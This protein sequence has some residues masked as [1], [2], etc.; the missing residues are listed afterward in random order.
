MDPF[1]IAAGISAL[2]GIFKGIT[3]LFRRQRRGP[4]RQEQ[5]PAGRERGRG[6]R[7]RNSCRP[8]TRS[9]PRGRRRRRQQRRRRLRRLQPRRDQP[10]LS[11]AM[12]NARSRRLPRPH[13]GAGRPIPGPGRQDP[14]PRPAGR[15]R[16]QAPFPRSSAALLR[17]PSSSGSRC[18]LSTLRGTG[19]RQPLR[20]HGR[21]ATKWRR[22]PASTPTRS[23]GQPTPA[24]APQ[25]TDFGLGSRTPRTPNASR[26]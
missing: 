4:D 17:M 5:R 10:T 12:F 26:R 14:G 25:T 18:Y 20:L 19:T 16:R 13:D 22:S 23:K 2:G 15:R 8:A 6:Q 7:A 11:Q 1:T 3:G 24:I 21:R 9:P